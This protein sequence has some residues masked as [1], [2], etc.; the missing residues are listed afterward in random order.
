[1]PSTK[2]HHPGPFDRSRLRYPRGEGFAGFLH[3]H[4]AAEL[5][6]RLSCVRRRFD[7]GLVAGPATPSIRAAWQDAPVRF[8]FMSPAH[9]GAEDLVADE[10]VPF[11]GAFPLAISLNA[12][13]LS[14]DP[15][16]M[17][18]EIRGA[19]A[20]DGLFLGAAASAG[21]LGE[22][23]DALLRAEAAVS[24]GAAMRVAP[25]SDVR[26]WGDA[27]AKAGFALPV[28][29]ELS[30]TVRYGDLSGL[31]RDLRA[32][33]ARGV[34]AATSPAPK[35]LFALAEEAYRDLH[36]DP[37]GR[38]RATFAFACLSGWAPD[39]GQ[40]KPARRGSA[41]VSLADALKDLG[42]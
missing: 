28:A 10:K 30:L 41:T 42:G 21:T 32:M 7:T 11:R 29:D 16:S 31:M 38:L 19:L 22:L 36:A 33:G 12:L 37:D 34:L 13:A 4:L 1:M 27:L 25:F 18:G 6:Q 9:T 14:N 23:C 5:I 35:R 15:V 40:P 24:G 8:T 2:S 3:E 17:L 39:P 26:R 20:P